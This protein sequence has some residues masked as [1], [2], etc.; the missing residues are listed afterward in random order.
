[1][2]IQLLIEP[3][4]LSTL[5]PAPEEAVLWTV[6]PPLHACPLSE[7]CLVEVVFQR[8][9]FLV[10]DARWRREGTLLDRPALQED[11]QFAYQPIPS[12]WRGRRGYPYFLTQFVRDLIRE[13]PPDA[14]V[15]VLLLHNPEDTWWIDALV[16]HVRADREDLKWE[17]VRTESGSDEAFCVRSRCPVVNLLASEFSE[18]F[19][20]FSAE[21]Q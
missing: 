20:S 8:R 3:E 10:I 13:W 11:L 6:A 9:P 7:Y 4:T 19:S 17:R 14:P 16:G 12:E 1:M 21:R 2:A 5:S 18:G 15:R